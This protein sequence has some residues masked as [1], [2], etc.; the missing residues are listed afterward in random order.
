VL[1]AYAQRFSVVVELSAVV[2]DRESLVPPLP[3]RLVGLHL[4]I[5]CNSD[6]NT[7]GGK[8]RRGSADSNCDGEVRECERVCL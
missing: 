3:I 6:N 7:N 1:V 4:A 2:V 5:G 8:L